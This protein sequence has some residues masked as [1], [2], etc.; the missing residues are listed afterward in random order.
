MAKRSR[1]GTD[2]LSWIHDSRNEDGV[3]ETEKKTMQP[4]P[5]PKR[6]TIS[7]M[8]KSGRPKVTRDPENAS[9]IGLRDGWTRATFIVR[10]KYLDKLKDLSYWNRQPLKEIVDEVMDDHLKNLKV[11]PR[12][13]KG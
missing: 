1:L 9:Q 8:K 5:L 11:K 7:G 6:T 4:Q 13:K 12:P 2:P 3:Q 10:E